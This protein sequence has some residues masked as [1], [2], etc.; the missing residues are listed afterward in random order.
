MFPHTTTVLAV[1]KRCV[2]SHFRINKY[3][4]NVAQCKFWSAKIKLLICL[5]FVFLND[6]L[7]DCMFSESL[8]LCS[9][10]LLICLIHDVHVK[11]RTT[12]VFIVG[13][14][15][16]QQNLQSVESKSRKRASYGRIRT[17]GFRLAW[18]DPTNN[19]LARES[20]DRQFS[21]WLSEKVGRVQNLPA[22][23]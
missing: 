13:G 12:N 8:I 20:T 14:D 9:D 7:R 4:L 6:Y 22:Q 2:F 1:R 11:A 10:V 15:G 19:A 16:G 5:W 21:R 3:A 18:M 17:F 23:T